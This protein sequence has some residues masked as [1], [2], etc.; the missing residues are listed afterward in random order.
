[1]LDKHGFGHHGMRTTRTGESATVSRRWRNRTA[2]SRITRLLRSRNPRN[3]HKFCNSPGTG[4]NSV[5]E[6]R[7]RRRLTDPRSRR[8]PPDDRSEVWRRGWDSFPLIRPTSITWPVSKLS[9]L[10]N[11]PKPEYQ[12]QNRYSEK[13][14]VTRPSAPRAASPDAD[15]N[16]PAAA[17]TVAAMS[18]EN[19]RGVA[20]YR[21]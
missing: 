4:W 6:P 2:K 20:P 5:S 12:V 8:A 13:A 16:R 1:V 10:S 18:S 15:P 11:H 7:R 3:A 14:P 21:P 17:S 19:A 9:I